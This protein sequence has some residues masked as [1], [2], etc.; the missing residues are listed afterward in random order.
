LAGLTY[1]LDVDSKESKGCIR[2]VY[3][4]LGDFAYWEDND[5]FVCWDMTFAHLESYLDG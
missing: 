5:L 2:G 4:P 3:S 1:A